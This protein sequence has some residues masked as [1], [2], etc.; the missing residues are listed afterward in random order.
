[1]DR[2]WGRNQRE[3]N[4][5]RNLQYGLRTRLVIGIYWPVRLSVEGIKRIA[6]IEK[7]LDRSR[8]A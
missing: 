2:A 6:K 8:M 4:S 5:V 7:W 1:M 3:T